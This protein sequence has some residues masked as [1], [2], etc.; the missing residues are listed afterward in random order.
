MCARIESAINQATAAAHG[1]MAA[2]NAPGAAALE[3]ARTAA[4]AAA[5]ARVVLRTRPPSCSALARGCRRPANAPVCV[6]RRA[7]RTARQRRSGRPRAAATHAT[8]GSG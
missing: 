2:T 3:S 5:A 8:D 6:A 1:S 7:S 4:E